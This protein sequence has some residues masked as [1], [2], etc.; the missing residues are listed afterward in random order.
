M[1]SI[2]DTGLFITFEGGEGAGKTTQIKLLKSYLEDKDYHVL[3][4]R[5]PG[6]TPEA[7]K[8]RDLLVQRDGGEWTSEAETLLLFAARHMHVEKLIKPALSKGTI[9]L[10]DRFTDST[11]AYQ[12]YGHG[13]PLDYVERINSFVLNEFSPDITFILDIDPEEGLSRSRSHLSQTSNAR[14]QSEDRFEAMELDFHRN[15]RR[16]FLEIADKNPERCHVIDAKKH[17][18]D[19]HISVKEIIDRHV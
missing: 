17:I 10:C 18:N 7:E 2:Q 15:L 11:R 5:E 3:L 12:S 19:I 1:A 16:G 9:V 4:T 6:G 13:M 8:I 14:E